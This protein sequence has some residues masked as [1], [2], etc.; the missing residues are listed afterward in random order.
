ML[1][2]AFRRSRRPLSNAQWICRAKVKDELDDIRK[3]TIRTHESA[4]H[5]MAEGPLSTLRSRPPHPSSSPF[6]HGRLSRRRL[7]QHRVRPRI[8]RLHDDGNASTRN[9]RQ[10]STGQ[11][12]DRQHNHDQ[13]KESKQT[14]KVVHQIPIRHRRRR[15]DGVPAPRRESASTSRGASQQNGTPGHRPQREA[16]KRYRS[17]IRRPDGDLIAAHLEPS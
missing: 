3:I 6:V 13:L 2:S 15:K 5:I 10:L 11:A 4:M 9:S 8:D 7:E 12:L 14:H 1:E 17:R 16:A